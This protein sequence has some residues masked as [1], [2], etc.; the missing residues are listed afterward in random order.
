MLESNSEVGIKQSPEADEGR[1]MGCNGDGVGTGGASGSGVGRD[2]GEGQKNEQ[3]SA[4][5]GGRDKGGFQ[6]LIGCS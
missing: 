5:G 3:Q 1:K 4:A 2:R 6:E